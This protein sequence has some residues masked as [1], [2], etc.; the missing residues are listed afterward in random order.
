[1]PV[2]EDCNELAV[3]LALHDI[4]IEPR[5]LFKRCR[6]GRR[7]IVLTERLEH[8]PPEMRAAADIVVPLAPPTAA[9][10]EAAA[11]EIGISGMTPDI[12]TLMTS[13]SFDAL[14]ATIIENRPLATVVRY[15]RRSA[16]ERARIEPAPARPKGP[17]L[18][19]MAGYGSAKT[20]GLQLAQDLR[21]WKAGDIAW[22]E[23]D[24][25]VLLY[26]PPGTG[27]TKYAT[28]LA[29]SCDVTL[30]LASA[31]RWQAAGHL[32]DYLKS[33]RAAFALAGKQAP[34]IL[35]VDEFDSFGDRESPGDEG[36]RDYKRQVINAML[37]CLDPADGREGVVVVGATN[38][39]AA[40]DR[41]LLRPGRLET[42]VEIPLPDAAARVAIL[43][44][45]LGT[46]ALTGDTNRFVTGTVG[47]SG[48]DI[49]KLARDAKRLSR[50]RRAAMTVDLLL[51]AMPA[52]Y[53]L[54]ENE[55]RHTA[56]HE[57]GHAIVGTVLGADLLEYV[58][59][60]R[61]VRR[62]I[63]IQSAGSTVFE[64]Q[65]GRVRT[66][67]YYNDHL[68]MLL[69]GIAAES[70]VYGKHGDGAGGSAG[71]DLAVASDI[72]TQ[73]EQHYGF[74]E[75]LSVQFGKGD[76]PLEDLRNKDPDLRRLVDRR[77]KAQ[78][79][80]ASAMLIDRRTELDLLA[81]QLFVTGRVEGGEVKAL[82]GL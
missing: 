60:E 69:G 62:G 5:A 51:E 11:R 32:G 41:A 17:R 75:V 79:E 56:V 18:E 36:H 12:A 64:R 68:A 53:A 16:V 15:L 20:W 63:S 74:G 9:H 81:A 34:S 6:Y 10:Y 23:V 1:M 33:M 35:F 45:H 61:E 31:A 54:S 72:A 55:L 38:S 22:E 44:H 14:S 77:L 39:P 19:D 28:A 66:V 29:N 21:A 52:T 48:A 70:V 76:R 27:K 49:E 82:C 7:I 8:V 3:V 30:V 4:A 71:S 37:E 67:D 25:G 50:S 47:W 24:R 80:R 40:I 65:M 57:A 42:L 13:F 26:G 58:R 46:N 73:M 43:R 2:D 78:F 59:I